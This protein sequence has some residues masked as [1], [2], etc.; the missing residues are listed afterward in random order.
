MD[1]NEFAEK[2][3]VDKRF[4]NIEYHKFINNCYILNDVNG[5]IQASVLTEIIYVAKRNRRVRSLLS[6]ILWFTNKDSISD[7]NFQL[8]L[9][10]SEKVRSQLLLPVSHKYQN[11]SV[12]RGLFI[13]ENCTQQKCTRA[14][15][16]HACIFVYAFLKEAYFAAAPL[17]GVA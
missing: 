5:N 2:I 8:L 13:N 14:F 7:E 3:A 10:F 15:L 11:I 12:R 16:L 4:R 1:I 6:G 17:A 9:T